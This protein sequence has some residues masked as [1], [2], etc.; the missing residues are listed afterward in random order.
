MKY[1]PLYT[2]IT[3]FI[4]SGLCAEES[5]MVEEIPYWVLNPTIEA[6]LASSDCVLFSENLSVMQK[7]AIMNSRVGI[8]QQ[9]QTWVDG[10]DVHTADYEATS[11]QVSNQK[12][13]GE[14]VLKQEYVNI[15]GKKYYCVMLI[16]TPDNQIKRR[17]SALDNEQSNELKQDGEVLSISQEF[18]LQKTIMQLI[19]IVDESKNEEL[20]YQEFKAYK[21]QQD[22]EKEIEKLTN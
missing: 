16:L 9:I 14:R 10:T 12:L 1:L 13:I 21:A 20:L 2:F 4:A 19:G 22:V 18:E 6:G 7:Q 15:V 3:F 17:L 5:K 8:V 11:K